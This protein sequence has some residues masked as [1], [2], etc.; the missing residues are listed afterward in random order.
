MVNFPGG[1]MTGN[2]PERWSGGGTDYV[3]YNSEVDVQRPFF[4]GIWDP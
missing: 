4:A 3:R 1:E 2:R